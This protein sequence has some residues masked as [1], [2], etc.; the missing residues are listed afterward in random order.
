MTLDPIAIQAKSD[1]EHDIWLDE[2]RQLRFENARLSAANSR[3]TSEL[4][5]LRAKFELGDFAHD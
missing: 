4:E 5:S 2:M 1:A 3:L